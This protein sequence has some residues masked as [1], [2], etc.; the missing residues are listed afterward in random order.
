[1]TKIQKEIIEDL[2]SNQCNISLAIKDRCT[3][4]DYVEFLKEAD[5][6]AGIEEAEQI[7]RDYVKS[8]LMKLVDDGDRLSILELSKLQRHSDSVNDAKRIRKEFMRLSIELA[9][10]K[11]RC[12]KEYCAVFN[13]SNKQS[14]KQ[15][16]AVVS[17]YNLTTPYERSKQK[18][19]LHDGSMSTLFDK[20]ELS[21]VDM[22]KRLL[23]KALYDSESSEYPSERS[24]ARA[25]VISINQRLDEIEEK[26]RREAETDK[27]KLPKLLKAFVMQTSNQGIDKL[28]IDMQSLKA[29]EVNDD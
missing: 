3:L 13:A 8:Q 19:K 16:E 27:T 20:G 5:F 7:E 26:K 22:Y 2:K 18:Q 12:L 17:E 14:E 10:T 24:K 25:D 11:S 23:S 1:M 28:D 9:E 21:E 6:R 4:E 29:L 15:Y